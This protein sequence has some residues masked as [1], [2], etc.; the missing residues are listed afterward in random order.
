M[1]R[2][3]IVRHL[4]LPLCTDDSLAIIERFAALDPDARYSQMGQYLP[5][6]EADKFPELRR[7]ITPREYKKVL[8]ALLDAVPA[9]RIYAQE[10]TAA[11][12]KFIPDFKPG[13]QNLF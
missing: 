7:R 1:V 10:L 3:C 12:E 4:V 5:C 6:G 11:D 8:N 2:G 9:E 13:D